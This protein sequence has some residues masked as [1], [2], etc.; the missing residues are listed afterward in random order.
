RRAIQAVA[1]AGPLPNEVSRRQFESGDLYDRCNLIHSCKW[2]DDVVPRAGILRQADHAEAMPAEAA[3]NDA[4][5]DRERLDAADRH[6]HVGPGEQTAA[7]AESFGSFLQRKSIVAKNG[8]AE[9]G[10][11]SN[12]PQGCERKEDANRLRG[13]PE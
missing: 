2:Y 6:D 8:T 4:R 3:A 5:R 12:Q 9:P 7:A 1:E 11:E 13:E 10:D